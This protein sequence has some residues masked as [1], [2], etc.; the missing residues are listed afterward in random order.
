MGVIGES[1]PQAGAGTLAL[2]I[3]IDL[4]IPPRVNSG[5]Q[6]GELKVGLEIVPLLSL[7]FVPGSV[8]LLSTVH[9]L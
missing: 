6:S 9:T 3:T 4:P 1:E 7:N 5:E 8:A 2:P